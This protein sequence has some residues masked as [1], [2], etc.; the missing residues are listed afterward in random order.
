MVVLSGSC[1]FIG[2][3]VLWGCDPTPIIIDSASYFDTASRVNGGILGDWIHPGLT[4]YIESQP[5]ILSP[6]PVIVYTSKGI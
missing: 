1:I 4:C 6:A 3:T 2:I 5:K